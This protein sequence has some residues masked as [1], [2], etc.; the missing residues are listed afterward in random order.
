VIFYF[1]EKDLGKSAK[2]E[3]DDKP[4]TVSEKKWVWKCTAYH[5]R[6]WVSLAYQNVLKKQ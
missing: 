3:I 6:L 5:Q 4:I 1:A 2:K